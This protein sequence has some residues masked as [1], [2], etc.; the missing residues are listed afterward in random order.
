MEKSTKIILGVI[1]FGVVLPAAIILPITSHQD[2]EDQNIAGI[3][4]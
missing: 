1:V 4:D 3:R 2:Y